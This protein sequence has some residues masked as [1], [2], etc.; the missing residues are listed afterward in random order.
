MQHALENFSLSKNKN[1]IVILGDMFELGNNASE[2]HQHIAKLAEDLNFE[3]IVL[4]G[5]NFKNVIVNKAIK[6][7]TSDEAKIWFKSKDKLNS[8]I[9]IKGSRGMKM[10]NILSE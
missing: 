4:V 1:R 7:D 9:L 8:E 3:K 5:K 2:E 10:E 6:F